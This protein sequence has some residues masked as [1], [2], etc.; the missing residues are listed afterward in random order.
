MEKE[1]KDKKFKCSKFKR[2]RKLSNSYKPGMMSKAS[3]NGVSKTKFINIKDKLILDL[4]VSQ[5]QALL[6]AIKELCHF[7]I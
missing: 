5:A 4:Q 2:K 3:F 7:A 1:R 6:L